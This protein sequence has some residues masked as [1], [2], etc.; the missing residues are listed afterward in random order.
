[1]LRNCKADV[2]VVGSGFCYNEITKS[3]ED[4]IM[5]LSDKIIKHRK[6]NG[7]PQEDCAAW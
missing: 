1:M 2:V 4:F 7:W 5:K 3:K 6:A